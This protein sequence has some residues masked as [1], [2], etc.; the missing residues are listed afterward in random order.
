M[1]GKSLVRHGFGALFLSLAVAAPIDAATQGKP[2]KTSSASFSI[3]LTIHP[4]LRSQVAI[5]DEGVMDETGNPAVIP[6]DTLSFDTPVALC[7]AGRGLSQ[8]SLTTEGN[9]NVNLQVSDSGGTTAITDEPS[10]LFA[11]EANCQGST[12]RLSAM[13]TENVQF[14]T[15]PATL[16]IHAN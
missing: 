11:T 4:S 9:E 15:Q 13:P 6:T 16:I 12:R 3:T 10:P 1:E 7:V 14:T 8:F 5:M 2:G